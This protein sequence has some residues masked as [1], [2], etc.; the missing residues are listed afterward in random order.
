MDD[1]VGNYDELIDYAY[2]NPVP[3]SFIN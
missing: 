1:N 3:D 2:G